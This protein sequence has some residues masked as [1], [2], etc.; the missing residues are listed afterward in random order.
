MRD[1]ILSHPLYIPFVLLNI[2]IIYQVIKLY[3]CEDKRNDDDDE[4]GSSFNDD[5]ILDLPPGVGLPTKEPS[6]KD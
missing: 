2:F 1:Y 3:V 4:G 6:L 5:P